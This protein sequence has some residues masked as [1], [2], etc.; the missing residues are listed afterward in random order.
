MSASLHVV[1]HTHIARPAA[2]RRAH[3]ATLGATLLMLS[4]AALAVAS[5]SGIVYVLAIDMRGAHF[6]SQGGLAAFVGLPGLL[7]GGLGLVAPAWWLRRSRDRRDALPPMLRRGGRPAMALFSVVGL[8]VLVIL[9]AASFRAIEFMESSTFCATCHGVMGP[10][11]EA[12]AVSPHAEVS[13]TKCHIGAE[14]G[15]VGPGAG[16]Y[17]K[18]KI[19]GMRQTVS[20]V[21]GDYDRPIRAPDGKIPGTRDTC[22]ACHAPDKDYGVSVRVYRSRLPDET[23]TS[24]QRVLAFR[25][26]GNGESDVPA[27]HWHAS[28]EVWYEPADDTRQTIG[29]VGVES[30]EGWREWRNPDVRPSSPVSRRLM[31]CTDCHNRVGH[32]IPFPGALID[33]AIDEGRLDPSLPYVK[34]EALALLGADGSAA[35]ADVQSER[36]RAP[37]WFDQLRDFYEREYPAIAAERTATIDAA[38]RELKAISAQTLYPDLRTNWQ[39]Y[40]NNLGH[41]LPDGLD[42]STGNATTGCFRCHG[43]L[44]QNDTGERMEG[45]SGGEGCMACHG[46][47]AGTGGADVTRDPEG[48]QG[49]ALCHVSVSEDDAARWIAGVPPSRLSPR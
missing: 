5:A 31:T 48:V 39:T 46:V 36:E 10:Q 11:V 41:S 6:S 30:D 34:R 2:T 49:C 17:I 42:L 13:C 38:I 15:P 44:V 22:E 23:N 45:T 37:G 14:A 27:I 8:T 4:G 29:W 9:G 1:R 24:H 28:A 47:A 26:G 33:K 18:S 35:D 40:A 21:L 3:A 19:G 12:H 16:E 43:T 7:L 25:V 20:V 32:E